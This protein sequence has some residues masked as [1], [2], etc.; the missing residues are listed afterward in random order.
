VLVAVAAVGLILGGC[1][2]QEQMGT[3]AH[4]VSTWMNAVGGS[5]IGN[6]EVAARNVDLAISRH[7]S[8]SAIREVCDLLSNEAQTSIGNLPA[9]DD[10][11]T[12]QLNNAYMEATAAGD[13]C[14]NGASGNTRLMARSAA[15]RTKLA[16]LLATAVQMVES[17]TGQ[18]PTTDTTAPQDGGDPFGGP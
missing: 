7:N 13:D 17:V 5:G 14:Y 2:G 16:S 9:P 6:V 11:L 4:R 18:T 15:E 8:P 1:A 10:Q 12:T 3:P